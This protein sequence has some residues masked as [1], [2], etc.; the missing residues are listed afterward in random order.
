MTLDQLNA[1]DIGA[2]VARLGGI[3]EHSPWV[4]ERVFAQRPFARIDA[5]HAAMCAV[6]D[7]ASDVEKLVLI[8]AHPQLAGKA[9]IRDQLTAASR[10]EQHGAGLDQCSADE[11]SRI[12][13]LN[14]AYQQRFGFPFILAVRG[15]GR[16]SIIANMAERLNNAPTHELDEALRQIAR[17]AHFRLSDLFQD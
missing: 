9:A 17:I 3:F 5:L 13:A 4:A 14:D 8:R 7:S 10:S 16:D 2:F 12:N 11:F 15:H 1:L 6:V